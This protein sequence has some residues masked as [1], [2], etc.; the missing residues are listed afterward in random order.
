VTAPTRKERLRPLEL[1]VMAAVVAVFIGLVVWGSTRELGLGAVFCG[2]A[3]IVSV[4][5]LAMLALS[6]KPDDPTLN[7]LGDKD[8]H[9]PTG[10]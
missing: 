7:D 3:F 2:V 9:G 1:L 5:T 4:L 10:H 6:A 8:R